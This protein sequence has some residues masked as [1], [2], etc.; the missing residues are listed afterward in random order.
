MATSEQYVES[1][2][3]GLQNL[4]TYL[5]RPDWRNAEPALKTVCGYVDASGIISDSRRIAESMWILSEVNAFAYFDADNGGL[6]ELA[7]W[8]ER[9]YNTI[10]A[11]N[12]YNTEALRGM[13]FGSN[14]G[15]FH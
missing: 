15:A 8:C 4:R 13:F 10:L 11:S 14:L 1:A 3:Q 5:Q 9:G 7:N 12:P 2:K 6:P